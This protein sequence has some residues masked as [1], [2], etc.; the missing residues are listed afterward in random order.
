MTHFYRA[1]Y[2]STTA[3]KLK[4]VAAMTATTTVL[5][6]LAI[7]M[8]DVAAGRDP[9]EVDEKFVL[10]ALQQGGGLGI[11]G[12]FVFSDVNRFGGGLTQT[13]TGPTGELLD[14]TVK[15]TLGNVREALSGEETNILGESAKILNRYTPDIWQTS[16]FTNALFD[17]LE[18]LADPKAQKK[19]NRMTRK[20]RTEFNQ[21]YWWK[22][23]ELT[24][25][26]APEL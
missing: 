8:K 6:G 22:R 23:G 19:F 9:R 14:T 17:Q 11:F 10:A 3:G 18:I 15:F 2:Q 25:D 24:P 21:D 26:R 4:Y 20:R 1:A 7:Q 5:G 12:D 16:L 13:L